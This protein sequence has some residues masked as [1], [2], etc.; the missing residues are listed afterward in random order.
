M[1]RNFLVSL[2]FILVISQPAMALKSDTS[3]PIQISSDKQSVD[4]QK[5]TITFSGNVVINQ[6]TIAITADK[7]IIHG[8]NNERGADYIE[9]FGQPVRFSQQQEDGSVVK[10]HSNNLN[11]NLKNQYLVLTT[12]VFFEQRNSSTKGDTIT[13]Q[14]KEQQMVASSQGKSPVITIINPADH[15]KKP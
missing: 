2:T 6:G 9:G 10:G 12:D 7:V 4:M 3:K 8:T 14:V 5:N 1:I 15:A 11:Y 13:Y